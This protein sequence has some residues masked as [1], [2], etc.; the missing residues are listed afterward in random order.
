M[1][2]PVRPRRCQLQALLMRQPQFRPSHLH[3][4]LR[5]IRA[6]TAVM[7][8]TKPMV[9][10]AMRLASAAMSVAASWATGKTPAARTRVRLLQRHPL[11]CQLQRRPQVRPQRPQSVL[12]QCRPRHRRL[13]PRHIRAS[14]AATA[15]TPLLA[16][17]AT[18]KAKTATPAGVRRDT[19]RV[20]KCRIFAPLQ[21]QLRQLPQR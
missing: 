17:C 4:L 8:V 14:M 6:T 16:V 5:H 3:Q 20:R 21:L 11:R 12:L 18:N 19:G 2:Q 1:R 15:V 13:R 7:A 9:A 10:S